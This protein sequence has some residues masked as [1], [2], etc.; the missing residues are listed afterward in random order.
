ML[1]KLSD[2]TGSQNALCAAT[3]TPDYHHKV[4]MGNRGRYAARQLWRRSVYTLCE[5]SINRATAVP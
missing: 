3:T 1:R 2:T 5:T 4:L